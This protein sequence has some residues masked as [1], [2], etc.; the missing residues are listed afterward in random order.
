MLLYTVLD[1]NLTGKNI[2]LIIKST[3]QQ[4]TRFYII[5]SYSMKICTK[6]KMVVT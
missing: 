4:H 6:E 5:Y 1:I 3:L 2:E